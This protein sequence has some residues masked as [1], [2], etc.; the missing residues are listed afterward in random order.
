MSA[1]KLGSIAPLVFVSCVLLFFPGCGK[2]NVG[3]IN[4]NEFLFDRGVLLVDDY[5]DVVPSDSTHDSFM[6]AI[7]TRCRQYTD[8]VYVYNVYG[9]G[10]GGKPPEL[11]PVCH[12][13]SLSEL[14]RYRLVIWD[15]Y[16]PAN[17]YDTGLS[18]VVLNGTMEDY[19]EAGGRLWVFGTEIIRGTADPPEGFLYPQEP[20]PSS[21]AAK[22]LKISGVVGRPFVVPAT[23]RD[24]FKRALPNRE[25]SDLLPTLDF[26]SAA[27]GTPPE[28]GMSSVEAVMAAMLEP[29]PSQR[30]DT[31]FFYGADS[32]TSNYDNK[33]CG[34]RFYDASSGSK[35]VYLGF[36]I[37]Y[38]FETHAESL[39]TYVTDW[40]LED[41]PDQHGWGAW[42]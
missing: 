17:E 28:Y 23:K 30:P 18:R 20:A 7:L 2:E 37:H 38:F 42:R 24:G 12:E 10:P 15:V 41:W 8:T 1:I 21:F 4:H 34:F 32:S 40:M 25:V 29:D 26:D 27:P 6:G 33:A 13:P 31:L 36:P 39:A 9:P 11:L 14:G 3:P 16:C 35:V 22:F 19:L 5:F